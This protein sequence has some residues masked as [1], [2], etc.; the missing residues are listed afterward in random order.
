MLLQVLTNVHSSLLV[1]QMPHVLTHLGH[2]H[3]SA[4]KVTLE[5]E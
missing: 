2:T 1:I 4:M 3:V 5:M